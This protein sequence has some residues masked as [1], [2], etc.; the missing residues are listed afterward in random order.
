MGFAFLTEAIM[1][2][3]ISCLLSLVLLVGDVLTCSL[4]HAQ[5]G[6]GS[7]GKQPPTAVPESR[8]PAPPKAAPMPPLV[9]GQEIAGAK[10]AVARLARADSLAELADCLTNMTAAALG[11]MSVIP[12]ALGAEFSD[13]ATTEGMATE[14][15]QKIK[16]EYQTLMNRYGLLD[17]KGEIT[18][19]PK[20]LHGWRGRGRRFLIDVDAMLSRLEKA[21]NLGT[22]DAKNMLAPLTGPK[23]P[24]LYRVHGPK[25]VLL[26][27]RRQP[28]IRLAEVR[29][30]EGKW[31][32]GLAEAAL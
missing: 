24:L 22:S 11:M 20:A 1:Q 32:L 12:I 5:E 21:G 25:R 31:R 4:A 19:D 26:F 23:K 17:R 28:K 7:A 30:E 3:K 2:P 29:W 10:W 13:G 27:D 18:Q 6:P 9:R 14:L 8:R 16:T 15:T